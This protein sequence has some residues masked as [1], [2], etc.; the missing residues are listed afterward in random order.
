MK[1]FDIKGTGVALVTPFDKHESIDFSSLGKLIDHCING[2]VNYLVCLG[3]TSEYPTLTPKELDA[4]RDYTLEYVDGRV[5]VVLGMGGNNTKEL[6]TKINHTNFNGFSAIL[7]VSPYYNKPSQ[8][9][10]I[11][12]YSFVA[13]SSPVPVIIYNVPSRT[14]SNLKAETVLQLA[15]ELD[16]I[17][18]VKEASGNM[19]QCM[20]ILR[21]KPDKFSLVSGEDALTLPLISCGANGVISVTANAFPDKVSQMVKFALKG[22]YKKALSIHNS[23]LPFTN[24]IF[25]EGNPAGVKSALNTLGLSE[26]VVRL[27]LSKVSKSLDNRLQSI[28]REIKK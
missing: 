11:S 24:A 9:G 27:P 6:V 7:T 21:C 17:I 26:N 20:E 8:K 14:G 13:S 5:P 23:L 10:L 18:G 25:E 19:S 3:T 12:H 1:S 28:I 15:E 2:G 16:N 4:L 22:S